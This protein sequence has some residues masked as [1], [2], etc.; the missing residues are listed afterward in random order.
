M[1]HTAPPVSLALEELG[2][3][4]RVFQHPGPV[5]SLEQAARERG[6]RPSQVVRSIVFR[7]GAD[8]FAMV[9]AAGPDQIDWKTL[10][11][12]LGQSRLTMAAESEVLAVTGYATGSV[13]PLGLPAPLPVYVD[14]SVT[15]EDEISIGSGVRGVTVILSSADLMRALHLALGRD[16]VM[17]GRFRTAPAQ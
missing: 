7:L 11:S 3:A 14:D 1:S 12:T 9:L 17:T 15:A 13:S 16:R 8:R 5:S 6:Q 10:R 2:V 4:H